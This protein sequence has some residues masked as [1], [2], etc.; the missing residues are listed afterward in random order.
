MA[1]TIGIPA[2]NEEEGIRRVVD[3]FLAQMASDD[4]LLVVASACTDRTAEEAKASGDDRVRVIEESKRNGKVAAINLL[5]REAEN[6]LVVLAD[7]D[8]VISEDAVSKISSLFDDPSVGASCAKVVPF[9]NE[10]FMDKVQGLGWR[11]LHDQK[12][13]ESKDG[14]FYALNGYLMGIRKA[15]IGHMEEDMI[16]DDALLG[17]SAKNNGYRVVYQAD[18]PVYVRAAQSVRD[19]LDQKARSRVGWLQMTEKG[20]ALSERRNVRQLLYL[21]KSPYAFAYVALDAIAWGIAWRRHKKKDL[22]WRKITS[23]KIS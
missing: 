1:L 8:V 3:A 4:E 18:L 2:Y 10:S 21:F 23:S 22:S 9:S 19:F 5:L 12:A 20:M 14:T 11:G 16:V 17:W 6:E 13:G 15:A 7:A